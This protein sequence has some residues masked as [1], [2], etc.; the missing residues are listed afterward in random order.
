MKAQ[1]AQPIQLTDLIGHKPGPHQLEFVLAPE[2]EVAWVSGFGGGKTVGLGAKTITHM[3]KWKKARCMLG[4]LTYDE[5]MSTTKKTFFEVGQVL[6]DRGYVEKPNKW[7]Y[8]ETTNLVRLVGGSEVVFKNLDDADRRYKNWELTF[9]GIDQGEENEFEVYEI[10]NN[11]L[12]SSMANSHIPAEARQMCVIANDGGYNWIYQRFHPEE[13]TDVKRRKFIHSTSLDNPHIDEQYKRDLMNNSP[14]WVAM[15][16]FAT[17]NKKVGRLLAD[18]QKIDSFTPPAGATVWYGH[19]HGESSVGS[20]HFAYYNDT[21]RILRGEG[22]DVPP[23]FTVIFREHWMEDKSVDEQVSNIKVLESDLNVISRSM[24]HTAFRLTQTKKGGIRN[25]L[26]DVYADCGMIFTPSIGNPDSR[27]ARWNLV[28]SQGLIVTRD[29]PNL[30]RQVP[31][32]HTKLNARTGNKEIVK[33]S[34]FHAVDSA[35]YVLMAMPRPISQALTSAPPDYMTD[36]PAHL[37]PTAPY[38]RQHPDEQSRSFAVANWREAQA[39]SEETA[40]FMPDD[41]GD[42]ALF[43]RGGNDVAVHEE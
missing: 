16:V 9:I 23:G 25:S 20:G 42:S 32:Y 33:K 3:L 41:Y 10:L 8:T 35:G 19:D 34:T 1:V 18:P 12:R 31:K 26:A 28:V 13:N 36:E 27:I 5:M 37:K 30:I 21:G 15:N 43:T 39:D 38:W 6:F 24:D 22:G 17:M 14:E 40:L 4:R 2:R 29:C 11:R 7:D